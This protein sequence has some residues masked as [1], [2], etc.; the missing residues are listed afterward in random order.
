[1]EKTT[2]RISSKAHEQLKQMAAEDGVSLTVELD[3]IIEA[4]RRQRFLEDL[5]T[6]Y[7][8]L[9]EEETAWQDALAEQRELEGTLM[10]GLE[11]DPYGTE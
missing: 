11:N 1:M 5:A 4:Q 6:D 9:R 2:V 8:A 7:A 3:Q 10:D